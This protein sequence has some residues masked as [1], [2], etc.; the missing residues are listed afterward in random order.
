MKRLLA[1]GLWL[2]AALL[3][4]APASA[5]RTVLVYQSGGTRS[6]DF[7]R[8]AITTGPDRPVFTL[9]TDAMWRS[10]TTADFARYNALWID[11]SNCGGSA[12]TYQAATD[13]RLVWSAAITGHFEIIGSDSDFHIGA[14]RKFTTNSYY[15]VSSGSGTGLFVSTG[16]IFAGA[17]LDTPVPWLQGIGDFRVQGDGCTDGQMLEP[18]GATHLVHLGIAPPGTTIAIATDLRWGCFTHSHFNR[19]PPSFNRVYSIGGLGPGRGVVIVNDRGGCVV[20]ADCLAGQ[21]C[22]RDP[23]GGDPTCRTT[24]GNGRPCTMNAQCT[25]GICTEGV[26]CN[27]TCSG[28]CESCRNAGAVGL[29]SPTV[30]NPVAPR[31]G[32]TAFGTTCGGR[33]DGMNRTM[34]TFPNTTTVCSAAS[35]TM[36]RA[37][38]A[39]NCDGAGACTPARTADCAPFV[40][41]PT[42]CLTRCTSDADCITGNTCRDGMCVPRSRPG[43]MCRAASDCAS[44]FCVDGVCCDSACGGQCEACDVAGAAGRCTAVMG[45]PRGARMAC[46]G[47]GACGGSCDGRT[48]NACTYAGM[49]TMCGAGSCT[50]GT[51]TSARFCD[52]A[53]NCAAATTRMCPMGCGP[54]GGCLAMCTMDSQCPPGSFCD[55]GMCTPRRPNGGMCTMANQC[56][57]G[58]C[59]DGVC[60]NTACAGQ[61]EACDVTG[62]AGTCSPVMGMPHGMRTACGG[63]AP[64][65]GAC[66]G[67]D[68][69]GCAFPGGMTQCREGMC[70]MGSATP[71][72]VCDGMGGCTPGMPVSCGTYTCD[73]ALC[74]TTCTMD[75]H[76]VAAHHCQAGRCVPNV[77]LG[78][79]CGRTEDCAAGVCVEGVCCNT[80]CNGICESCVLPGT[81]GT[82]S[83]RPAGSVP[84]GRDGGVSVPTNCAACDGARGCIPPDAGAPMDAGPRVVYSGDGCKCRAQRYDTRGGHLALG[85][86]ALGLLLA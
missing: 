86:V 68:R 4:A 74:R 58:N 3:L 22:N 47:S 52:G 83:P 6:I 48:R 65:N 13:T 17:A 54:M 23:A 27:A 7:L 21:F 80:A 82:C 15:Y 44:G 29:C 85:L 33:C 55:A 34:C 12:A 8:T 20:D 45:T 35:C 64:C 37:T 24:L 78:Q 28:Q 43:E 77:G 18:F 72:G 5:Q 30:G 81:R 51:E 19:H 49:E 2:G 60:C 11:G 9:A 57:S 67:T 69:T 61:C 38:L 70:S 16:C 71:A 32:C 75:S 31:T 40:C 26:C 73:G 84:V 39:A 76:C 62:M 25:S 41:G 66:D 1:F 14:S 56:L 42:A 59:V 10:L 79:P 63:T 53:G 46:I 50:G 36:G